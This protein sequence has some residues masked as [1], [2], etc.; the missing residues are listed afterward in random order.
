MQREFICNMVFRLWRIGEFSAGMNAA[1][2]KVKTTKGLML[3]KYKRQ[4][5]VKLLNERF[6][7][8][9]SRHSQQVAE[10]WNFSLILIPFQHPKSGE[11]GTK[12]MKKS[13][14]VLKCF[15]VFHKE[16]D[17]GRALQRALHPLESQKLSAFNIY[18]ANIHGRKIE[19][20]YWA[21]G[22]CPV[23]ISPVDDV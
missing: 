4:S 8:S 20:I 17:T 21:P 7:P 9:Q 12:E 23:E 14:A 13:C 19:R 1:A 11:M 6:C 22:N 15:G 16:L 5:T 10:R 3:L 2:Y 18:L